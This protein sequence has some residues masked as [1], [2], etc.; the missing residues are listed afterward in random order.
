MG[1]NN[2]DFHGVTYGHDVFKT[3]Q[4]RVY[5]KNHRNELIAHMVFNP[6]VPNAPVP[7]RYLNNDS[8]KPWVAQGLDSKGLKEGLWNYAKS[9]GLNP[10]KEQLETGM[11]HVAPKSAREGISGAGLRQSLV[12]PGST[13]GF[14]QVP[15]K[16]YPRGV[17]VSNPPRPLYG[18]DI[19]KVNQDRAKSAKLDR[20]TGDKY[21]TDRVGSSDVSRVGHFF[22]NSN[23]APEIHWHPEEECDGKS[24]HG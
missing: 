7:G 4:T 5:A 16:E 9:A 22:K 6:E 13:R 1:A 15:G 18:E 10:Q 19:W 11:F 12:I 21:L 14:T 3:G 17:F 20:S 8:F 23:G 24:I 2:G